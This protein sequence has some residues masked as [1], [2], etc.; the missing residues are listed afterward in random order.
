MHSLSTVDD[1][2]E[3]MEGGKE[4]GRENKREELKALGF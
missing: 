2:K 3:K 1:R 4:K